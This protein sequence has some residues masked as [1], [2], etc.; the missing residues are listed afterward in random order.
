MY[1][2]HVGRISSLIDMFEV[3]LLRSVDRT[4]RAKYMS[5]ME[6]SMEILIFKR[7]I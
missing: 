4:A 7:N 2:F 5:L 1:P 3:H 6:A